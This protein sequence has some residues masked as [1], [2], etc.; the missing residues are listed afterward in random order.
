MLHFLLTYV[1]AAMRRCLI[2]SAA[3]S[4]TGSCMFA[5]K[6]C[7]ALADAFADVPAND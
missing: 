5:P 6:G 4:D 7:Q 1:H 3:V 2:D